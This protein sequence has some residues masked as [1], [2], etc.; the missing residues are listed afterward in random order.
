[1]TLNQVDWSY[2]SVYFLD[3]M[4]TPSSVN[5]CVYPQSILVNGIFSVDIDITYIAY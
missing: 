2:A 4:F 1:M 5:T 3:I